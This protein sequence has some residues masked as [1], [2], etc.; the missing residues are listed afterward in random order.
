M[1]DAWLCGRKNNLDLVPLRSLKLESVTR[2]S[3]ELPLGAETRIIAIPGLGRCHRTV[4]AH[5]APIAIAIIPG[6]DVY[7]HTHTR[8][9]GDGELLHKMSMPAAYDR[10]ADV[11]KIPYWNYAGLISSGVD[12]FVDGP[13][14]P[15]HEAHSQIMFWL[16]AVFGTTQQSQSSGCLAVANS[17]TPTAKKA[18]LNMAGALRAELY[19]RLRK[20]AADE[21]VPWPV[22]PTGRLYHGLGFSSL[23]RTLHTLIHWLPQNATAAVLP[24]CQPG[25]PTDTAAESALNGDPR[26]WGVGGVATTGHQ[27]AN[28]AWGLFEDR[29]GKPGWKIVGADDGPGRP[30]PRPSRQDLV[31]TPPDSPGTAA[32]AASNMYLLKVNVLMTYGDAGEVEL[33]HCGARLATID[34]LWKSRFSLVTTHEFTLPACPGLAAGTRPAITFRWAKHTRCSECMVKIIGVSLCTWTTTSEA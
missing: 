14:H 21:G 2:V 31:F 18:Q 32:A 22:P 8:N 23:N 19:G 15:N 34:T 17:T 20:Q 16:A 25:T 12:N 3:R 30:L 24:D 27:P 28:G 10:A 7:T 1:I 29:P 4:G 11:L 5:P 6:A 33:W 26:G 9:H 13:I